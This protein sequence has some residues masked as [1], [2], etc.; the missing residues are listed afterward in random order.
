MLVYMAELKKLAMPRRPASEKFSSVSLEAQKELAIFFTIVVGVG[1][2][3]ILLWLLNAFQPVFIL[4]LMLV[5]LIIL[6]TQSSAFLIQVQEYERAVVFRMGRFNRIAQPGW[7]VLMPFMETIKRLDMRTH[8]VDVSPQEVVTRD[9][10]KLTLD[11][12]L[13]IH[14]VD[15]KKAVLNVENYEGAAIAYV[16]A[17]LRDVVGKMHL[18]HVIS[19]IDEINRFL[20]HGLRE[21][22]EDWGL[23]I[24]KVEIQTLILPE[25]LMKAMHEKKAAEQHRLASV[26]KAE[27][28]RLTIEAI[29]QAAGKLTSPT[30]QYMYMQSL[31]KIAEGKSNK[32][33][34]PLELTQLASA[35]AAKLQVPFEKAQ[36]QVVERYRELEKEG[37]SKK[38]AIDTLKDEIGYKGPVIPKKPVKFTRGKKV[39]FDF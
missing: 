18:E 27:A 3:L 21:I 37:E 32:L 4:V 33:I 25:T 15:P 39:E 17:H 35:F 9:N 28:Q 22:S 16:K 24:D 13:F 20:H 30:L 2:V 7:V 5:V 29:Q 8:T 12:I 11:A 6:Y 34:F 31:Q 10:I 19:G 38:D 1:I 14:I 36:D 23:E 26:E